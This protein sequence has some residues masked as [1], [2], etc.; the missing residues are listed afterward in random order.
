MHRAIYRTQ[1]KLTSRF[2]YDAVGRKA[3]Q[4]ASTVEAWKLSSIHNPRLPERF[5]L[6]DTRSP[7]ERN[8]A[9]TRLE[10][11]SKPIIKKP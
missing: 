9:T 6:G 8:T 4:Y 1:G 7:I 5:L 11:W 3:F 2:G 10:N